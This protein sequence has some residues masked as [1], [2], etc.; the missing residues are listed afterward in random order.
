MVVINTDICKF[1]QVDDSDKNL[2]VQC[3]LCP[4]WVHVLCIPLNCIYLDND[5]AVSARVYPNSDKDINKFIC[6]AHGSNE[7]LILKSRGEKR[8]IDQISS[9]PHG[10]NDNNSKKYNLRRGK[11]IDYIS[12]NEGEQKKLKNVHPHLANFQKCFK[13]WEN[14]K[15]II[16]S[17]KFE[18]DFNS[19]KEPFKITDPELSGME[20]PLPIG[21]DKDVELTVRDVTYSVGADSDVNVMDVL[22]QQNEKW[23][24][25]KWNRY[26]SDT[27]PEDRERLKNVISLEVSHVKNFPIE[28][29][30]AVNE[31]DLVDKVWNKYGDLQLDG[32]EPKVKKYVLMSVG[33]AYTDFHL[34]FAGTSVYYRVISGQKQFILFPPTESNL[35]KYVNW[36]SMYEQS[37]VFLGDQLEDG[38]AMQLE[39][40]D[41]FMI[42]CGYIHVV[43][44]PK[45]SLVIGGNFL[46]AR[47]I[48][49]QLKIVD[50]E[51]I[52]KVPKRFTFPKFDLVMCK[53]GEWLL[54]DENTD[55]TKSSIDKET[56]KS[57]TNHLKNSSVKYK[58]YRF[59]S[60]RL[61]VNELLSLVNS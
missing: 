48:A 42:P 28:R 2:W 43:Y 22:N 31:N 61:L 56:I 3:E 12:L 32:P 39:A 50:I 11:K 7:R 35:Q 19:I 14:T 26:F 34:D 38:I 40:G 4:Q 17:K 52:T 24:L 44:T 55:K 8:N 57:L 6:D 10:D 45:D 41:L 47:D 23:T 59:P 18:S 60:K 58:S 49:T 13:K 51:R 29:P 54:D 37:E 9:D 20:L 36:C 46:T 30:R 33:N 21:S 16:D 1:C 25:G 53:T 15:N 5:T 27:L